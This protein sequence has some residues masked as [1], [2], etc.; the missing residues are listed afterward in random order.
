MKKKSKRKEKFG[1]K[2]EKTSVE[3]KNLI[4]RFKNGILIQIGRNEIFKIF[5]DRKKTNTK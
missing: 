5:C 3:E 2:A 1:K 4:F